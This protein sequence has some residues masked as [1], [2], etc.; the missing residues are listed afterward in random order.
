MKKKQSSDQSLS[1]KALKIKAQNHVKRE[2]WSDAIS[3]YG[4]IERKERKPTNSRIYDLFNK[5]AEAGKVNNNNLALELH[6]R[7]LGIAPDHSQGMRNFA[8]LMRRMQ[9]FN[10]AEYFIKRYQEIEP[11]CISGKNTYGT[12]LSD[13]G[14][15]GEAISTFKE[16]L[17]SDPNNPLANSNIA[18][19]YH[20]RAQID[21]A[22]A[23]SS[24]A[25]NNESILTLWLDHITHMRRVCD[26]TNLCKIDPISLINALPPEWGYTSFLNL[27][28]YCESIEECLQ[29]RDTIKRWGDS[30]SKKV[31]LY[32]LND[33]SSAP[34]SFK[35]R[36]RIGF[37]SADFRD[38]SVARFI[39]PLFKKI[40][41]TRFELYGYSTYKRM[42]VWRQRFEDSASTIRDV[43]NLSPQ[44]LSQVIRDDKINVLF[45]LTGFTNGSRTSTFAWKAAPIQVSWLGFPGTCGLEQMDYLFLDKYLQPTRPELIIEKPLITEGSSIC[46]TELDDIPITSELPETKRGYITFGSLNNTYK[47]TQ[48]TIK[49]WATVMKQVEGSKFLFIR[50]EFQSYILRQNIINEFAK[51]DIDASRIYFYNNRLAKRHYLDCYNE[52][53]ICLDTYPVTGG[54]TT[55]DS[56]WMGVPVITLEGPAIHQ[57]VCSSILKHVGFPEWVAQNNQQFANI[58]LHLSSDQEKRAR[59]R[60][61]LRDQLKIS[62]LCNS[63]KFVADFATS[64]ESIL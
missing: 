17:K 19:E 21:L 40:D 3:T 25:I 12:I 7:L 60:H 46:F 53:D 36:I 1:L 11:D 18:N 29:L 26:F 34:I 8:V 2:E 30:Q 55:I 14:K 48:A 13:L 5:G 47:Y 64:I 38:H 45:D 39:W 63:E 37:I 27:L 59:V 35:D 62:D 28:V 41:K 51:H 44:Q 31:C 9:N 58:A 16:V 20:L 61:T 23:H 42:D 22:F 15:N 33:M 50:V 49:R 52:I 54:T 32:N 43:E 57:R 56:L 24:R 6:C 10:A 4:M